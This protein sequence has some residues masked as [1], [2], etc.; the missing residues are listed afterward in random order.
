[1]IGTK[2]ILSISVS[3]SVSG[4]VFVAAATTDFR[5][6]GRGCIISGPGLHYGFAVINPALDCKS[7]Q[8]AG[9]FPL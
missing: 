1:M 9:A 6:S 5:D 2:P 3:V 4:V 8:K 7:D